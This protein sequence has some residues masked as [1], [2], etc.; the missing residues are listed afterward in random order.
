MLVSMPE[1]SRMEA[2]KQIA[3]RTLQRSEF[4]CVAVGS[5]GK[6][7]SECMTHKFAQYVRQKPLR[8]RGRRLKKKGCKMAAKAEPKQDAIEVLQSG[9]FSLREVAIDNF[10]EFFESILEQNALSPEQQTSLGESIKK[11]IEKRDR[12]GAFLERLELEGEMLKKEEARLAG[13]RRMFERIGECFRDSIHT[14]MT[15]W[16]V[17]KAEGQRFTFTVKKNP[18]A[19]EVVDES[20]IPAEFLDYKPSVNRSEIKRVLSE[21]KEVPGAQLRQGTRLEVK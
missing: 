18:P 9:P 20:I 2:R 16:G 15:E 11:S 6:G 14:Q 1:A 17:V 7:K 4:D 3:R 5:E 8:R 13:R 19:V 21:G 12:L 10:Q